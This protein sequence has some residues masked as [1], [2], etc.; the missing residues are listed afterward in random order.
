[1]KN[2]GNLTTVE[3]MDMIA[4]NLRE[5]NSMEISNRNL[6]NAINRAKATSMGVKSA[7]Q[8]AVYDSKNKA[9]EKVTKGVKVLKEKANKGGVK[10][11]K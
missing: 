11:L 2:N 3:L 6:P 5:M 7:L 8:L 9:H 1:M 4:S 10:L